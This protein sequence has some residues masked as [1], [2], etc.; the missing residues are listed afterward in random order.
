MEASRSH[1]NRQN[2]HPLIAK[3][4]PGCQII[5]RKSHDAF[6]IVKIITIVGQD[7]KSLLVSDIVAMVNVFY[8]APAYNEVQITTA[9]NNKYKS[10][11]IAR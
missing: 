2:C 9:I 3:K 10:T 4:S 11:A 6:R 5:A 8:Y 7:T 1:Q